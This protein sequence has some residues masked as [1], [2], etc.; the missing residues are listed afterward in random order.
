MQRIASRTMEKRN[1]A[2]ELFGNEGVRMAIERL[3]RLRPWF[4]EAVYAND[5]YDL[6]I[7]T[8]KHTPDDVCSMIE[9]RLAAGPG[10]AFETL[11]KRHAEPQLDDD[12]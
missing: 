8:V 6:E 3:N 12:T 7:D 4:Y 1:P 5:C 2:Q 11:R 9:Q 10:T